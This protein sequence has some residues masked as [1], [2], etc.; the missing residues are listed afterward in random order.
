M[1]CCCVH[2]FT[3]MRLHTVILRQKKHVTHKIHHRVEQFQRTNWNSEIGCQFVICRR[4]KC[5]RPLHCAEKG[6]GPPPGFPNYSKNRNQRLFHNT[7][8]DTQVPRPLLT[9]DSASKRRS[10]GNKWWQSKRSSSFDEARDKAQTPSQRLV[11]DRTVFSASFAVIFKNTSQM[12]SPF[13]QK[14]NKN[15]LMLFIL[16]VVDLCH[17]ELWKRQERISACY[18]Q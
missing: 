15:S 4:F 14:Q 6:R 10:D 16:F 1:C 17:I 7:Y 12:A 5:H 3:R 8:C 9:G 11:N 2:V 13:D 18:D